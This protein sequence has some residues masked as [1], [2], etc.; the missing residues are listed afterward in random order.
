V[1]IKD[2]PVELNQSEQNHEGQPADFVHRD[3]SNVAI[4]SGVSELK[5]ACDGRESDKKRQA[6]FR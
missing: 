6:F 1:I 4:V 3:C 2:L 5:K